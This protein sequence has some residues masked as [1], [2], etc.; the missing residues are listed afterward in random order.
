MVPFVSRQADV[1]E[2]GCDWIDVTSLHRP[3]TAWRVIDAAGHP[4]QW[5]TAEHPA[6]TYRPS[7]AYDVPT[8]RWVHDGWGYY[9]DGERYAI[10]HYECPSCGEWIEPQYRADDYTQ[11]VPGL[12]WYTINGESVSPDEFA[13]RLK[14]AQSE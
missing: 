9:D 12:R 8:L 7:L 11:Y 10:G 6:E 2:T 3:D 13:Q 5:Y 4:H 1:F 14:A